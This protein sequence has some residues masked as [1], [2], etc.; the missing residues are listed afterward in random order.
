MS[1]KEKVEDSSMEE[2]TIILTAAIDVKGMTF[3]ER[4]DINLREQDYI[5][6]LTQ[7]MKTGLPIIFCENSGYDLT[8][9]YELTSNY[10]KIEIL[11]FDGQNFDKKLGKGFGEQKII[12]YVAENSILFRKSKKLMKVTGRY[13]LE[14]IKKFQESLST[15]DGVSVI[16]GNNLTFADGRI[17]ISTP[18][19]ITDYLFFYS[20]RI[21]D[22]EGFYFEHAVA[23]AVHKYMSDGGTWNMLPYYPKVKGYS[24]TS[25][26]KNSILKEYKE[27]FY[28]TLELWLLNKYYK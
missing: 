24:G 1:I 4:S 20:S 23:H 22:T 27:N 26:T 6:A 25:N 2:L 3:T 11:Q 16:L 17:I 9:I 10:E 5:N 15:N 14:N 28:Y 7:W 18:E 13:Y 8:K 12:R 21:N 19:F